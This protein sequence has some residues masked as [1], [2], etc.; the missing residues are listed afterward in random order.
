MAD[1]NQAPNLVNHFT[2]EPRI[3]TPDYCQTLW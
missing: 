2:L 1:A 3:L